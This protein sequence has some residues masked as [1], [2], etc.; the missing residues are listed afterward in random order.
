MTLSNNVYYPRCRLGDGMSED[1]LLGG[2]AREPLRSCC[3]KLA[4]RL[5][6]L[7]QHA[8]LGDTKA[9]QVG[10]AQQGNG[11]LDASNREAS[12]HAAPSRQHR[13]TAIR[14][15]PHC[16]ERHSTPI[17]LTTA[18]SL[19]GSAAA[20]DAPGLLPGPASL[21]AAAVAVRRAANTEAAAG[22]GRLD[23]GL[24]QLA[25]VLDP[26]CAPASRLEALELLVAV[27]QVW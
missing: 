19:G 18:S 17:P 15:A 10:P 24:K 4:A 11:W 6:A 12:H 3:V 26:G 16:T 21:Q 14:P 13:P 27:L 1:D 23:A 9:L 8:E 25:K 5:W 2:G 20:P 22:E 7:C